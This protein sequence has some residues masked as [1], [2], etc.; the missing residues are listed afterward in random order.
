MRSREGGS[1]GL[2]ERE[3]ERHREGERSSLG[4]AWEAW[5]REGREREGSGERGCGFRKGGR[6]IDGE[7]E[8]LCYVLVFRQYQSPQ[9]TCEKKYGFGGTLH[10]TGVMTSACINF[11]K[12]LLWV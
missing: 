5:P 4:Q 8:S 2:R 9:K 11:E 6:E 10:R 1:E 12:V 7:G 3:G